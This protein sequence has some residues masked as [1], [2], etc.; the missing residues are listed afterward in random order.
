MPPRNHRPCPLTVALVHGAF[1]DSIG[2]TGVIERLTAAG[3]RPRRSPNPLRGIAADAAYVASSSAD[4]RAGPRRRPLLRR[5]GH[6]QCRGRPATSSAWSTSPRSPRTRASAWPT[7]EGGLHRQRPQH[8]A[9]RVAVPDRRG[10]RDGYRVRDRPGEV[11]RCL[12]RGPEPAAGRADGR[13]PAPGLR[14]RRSSSRAGRRP[15]RRCPA[16]PWSPPR[17]GPRAATSSAPWRA[18]GH[19]HHRGRGLAR[20][21]HLAAASRRR[22][23]PNRGPRRLPPD[24]LPRA[25]SRRFGSSSPP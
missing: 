22:R 13:D 10:R 24:E 6:H 17:T 23:D 5:R 2:W 19:D 21:L 25:A 16:G 9:G 3:V 4:P 18:R 11:P 20:R 14:V 8:R 12:R 7:I 15:G 1:A